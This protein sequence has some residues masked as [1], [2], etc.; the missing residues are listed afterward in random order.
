MENIPGMMDLLIATSFP[1]CSV[2]DSGKLIWVLSDECDSLEGKEV[3]KTD[4]ICESLG[5]LNLSMVFI[6]EE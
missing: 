1:V 3:T 2:C 4:E 6:K 5:F